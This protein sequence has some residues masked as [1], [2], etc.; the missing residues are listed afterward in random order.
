MNLIVLGGSAASPNTGAGC[1]GY[2]VTHGGAAAARSGAGTLHELRRHA[3]F[4]TLSAVVVTHMHLAQVLDL[5]ALR[6]ALAD[7]PLPAP[8][9]TPVWLPPAGAWRLAA[10]VAPSNACDRPGRFVETVARAAEH[11]DSGVPSAARKWSSRRGRRTGGVPAPGGRQDGCSR[12]VRVVPRPVFRWPGQ[13][14][15]GSM[16]LPS[17]V[18]FQTRATIGTPRYRRRLVRLVRPRNG[19]VG[20]TG[21][22]RDTCLRSATTHHTSNSRRASC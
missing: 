3:D 13:S 11:G 21:G 1:S 18:G 10:A 15:D 8:R 17:Q 22:G 2:L 9:S 12:G 14:R 19:A 16:L 6:H 7:N 20:R 4:R 5:L